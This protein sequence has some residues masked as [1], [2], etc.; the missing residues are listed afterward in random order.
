MCGR[1]QPPVVDSIHSR[2]GA[3][4]F[5]S[6]LRTGAGTARAYAGPRAANRPSTAIA[7]R[8]E[9]RKHLGRGR[10]GEVYEAIDRS[11]SDPQLRLE[12]AV[13]LHLLSERISR[14]TRV[15]QKLEAC[16]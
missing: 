5:D 14:Q 15:L 6:P 3:A 7:N 2:S 12:H 4:H 11:F 10:Y 13:A 9:L 1:E 8:Y 16:Y